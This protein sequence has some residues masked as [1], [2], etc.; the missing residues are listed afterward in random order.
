M[1]YSTVYSSRLKSGIRSGAVHQSYI[2][3]QFH[4]LPIMPRDVKWFDT[5]GQ[6]LD[7][8]LATKLHNERK[9]QTD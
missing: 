7:S 2:D 6:L 8:N 3:S 5:D 1:V 9:V 4:I